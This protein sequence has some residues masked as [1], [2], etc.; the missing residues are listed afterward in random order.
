[1]LMLANGVKTEV[2]KEKQNCTSPEN[3]TRYEAGYR[4][5]LFVD[6]VPKMFQMLSLHQLNFCTHGLLDNAHH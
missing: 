2:C 5:C 1:M 6:T 3:K 4:M